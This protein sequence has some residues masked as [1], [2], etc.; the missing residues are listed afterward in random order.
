MQKS[1][2]KIKV[3]LRLIAPYVSIIQL[4]QILIGRFKN[5]LNR[6]LRKSWMLGLDT[7]NE[8]NSKVIY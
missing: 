2:G 7:S 5:L 1:G 3:V 8:V 6:A 4:F